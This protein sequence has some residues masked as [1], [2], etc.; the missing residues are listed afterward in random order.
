MK[1]KKTPLQQAGHEHLRH[2][3]YVVKGQT[4]HHTIDPSNHWEHILNDPENIT[5]KH[6]GTQV[7]FLH[8]GK[9]FASHRIKFESQS[10]PLGVI[11]GSGIAVGK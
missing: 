9:V 7:H 11:K 1:A 5:V 2:T 6:S 4:K 3:T 8:H 10:D